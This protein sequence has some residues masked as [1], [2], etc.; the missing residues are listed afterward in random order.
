MVPNRATH[1]N[2][3]KQKIRKETSEKYRFKI[4]C[5]NNS[6]TRKKKDLQKLSNKE[7]HFNVQSDNTKH[8]PFNF[9]SWPNFIEGYQNLSPGIWGKIFA[10]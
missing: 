3:W 7:V 9:I 6:A 4:F 10:D 1:H 8:K 2:Y 5:F